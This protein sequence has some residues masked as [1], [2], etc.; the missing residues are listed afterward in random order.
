MHLAWSEIICNGNPAKTTFVSLLLVV[1]IL[2]NICELI[3]T[4]QTEKW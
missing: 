3:K 4:H 2:K 1:I